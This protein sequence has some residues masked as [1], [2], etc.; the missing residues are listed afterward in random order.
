MDINAEHLIII[1]GPSGVGEDSIIEALAQRTP[2]TRVVTTTTRAP[3]E[4]ESE[5][6]PYYFIS[7]DE[8]RRLIDAG[9]FVEWAR[10]YNDELYGV[11]ASELRRVTSQSG[12]AVWKMEFQGVMHVKKIFPRL[13][14]I[15]ILAESLDVLRER[16]R[17]RGE[18]DEYIETR[19]EYTKE[20]LNHTDIYDYT[21]I[22]KQGRLDEAVDELYT[23]LKENGYIVL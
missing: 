10:E 1:S 13:R 14:A 17:L 15:L 21:I 22:N 16:L 9:E 4:G 12:L 19:M 6:H 5:G 2:L 23:Y 8:F 20:W 3:R 11:T 18:T 7:R